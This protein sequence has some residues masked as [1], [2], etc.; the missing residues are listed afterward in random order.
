MNAI[1]ICSFLGQ[2]LITLFIPSYVVQFK[3]LSCLKY[4]WEQSHQNLSW[5]YYFDTLLI[6]LIKFDIC[7]ASHCAYVY[8]VYTTC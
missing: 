5:T 2:M 4:H 1:F 6:H 8:L 7:S 3:P